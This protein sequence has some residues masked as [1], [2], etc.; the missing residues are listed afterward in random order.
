MNLVINPLIT[1]AQITTMNG[2]QI[3]TQPQASDV[4]TELTKLITLLSAGQNGAGR[5]AA[6]TTA[7]CA[8]VLG[9]AA[10]MLH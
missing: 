3:V 5:T 7:A 4:A 8:A 10:V 9:S 6:V 2:T 1:N